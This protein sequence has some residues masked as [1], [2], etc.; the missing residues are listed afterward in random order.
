MSSRNLEWGTPHLP[1]CPRMSIDGQSLAE[2]RDTLTNFPAD[3]SVTRALSSVIEQWRAA[4]RSI[5][6]IGAVRAILDRIRVMPR[7]DDRLAAMNSFVRT[8]GECKALATFLD[9]LRDSARRDGTRDEELT[10]WSR[11]ARKHAVYGWGGQTLLLFSGFEP[12]AGTMEPE[13]GVLEL[14]GDTP[15]PAVWG[16]SMHIWQPNPQAKG[17]SSGARIGYGVIVEPP[18]SHP[19]DFASMVSTGIMRQ[20]IY[21]QGRTKGIQD[22]GRYDNVRLEHVDGVWPEHLYRSTCELRTTEQSVVLKAGDSYYLPC[23]MIHDVEFDATVAAT[24]PAITL[25]L[26]SEATVKPHVYIAASMADAHDADPHMKEQGG[27]LPPDAWEAKL[28]AVSAYLRGEHAVLC[29]DEI[30][31]YNG[32]YAFFHTA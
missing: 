31:K 14:L 15:P 29:L 21:T 4:P 6:P 26:A 11:N 18:H 19:F 23:D 1:S 13:A 3:P 20:S 10:R 16:L 30:V 22:E 27:A 28:E 8:L 12:T 17:F 5:E 25:F 32:E 2:I 7:G 9:M 24:T